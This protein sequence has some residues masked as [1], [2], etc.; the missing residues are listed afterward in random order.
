M[1]REHAF[2]ARDSTS[3]RDLILDAVVEV[4]AERGVAGA[5]VGLVIARTKVSRR[6]FYECFASLEDC[7]V[8][9]L[10]RGLARARPLIVRGFADEGSWR[11]G[12][13]AALAAMLVFCDREIELVRVCLV[14]TLAA[15][16]VVREHR[17]RVAGEFREL[18]VEG[19]GGEV[20]H[21][22]WLAPEGVLASVVGIAIS[23][24]SSRE[25]QPLLGLLGP[26]M[27]IIVGPFVDD[28]EVAREIERGNELARELLERRPP[29]IVAREDTSVDVPAALLDP[30]AHRARNCLLYL[31]EQGARGLAP[32]NREIADG[33]GIRSHEQIS[34]L[35]ARL[36]GIGLLVKHPGPRGGANAWSLTDYGRH[37]A[38][39]LRAEPHS[40]R[41]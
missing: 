22:S 21:A 24:L 36:A 30:R 7:L 31:A 20:S 26:L 38:R 11:D 40:E 6:A 39:A 12:M 23:R 28:A 15:G 4:V 34:R 14:E 10:D 2:Q 41:S 25:P 17:E 37:V 29:P 32:S 13:R 18:V 1:R 8:A 9:V 16:R 3:R 19:V 5:A 27:G 35:L 33:I